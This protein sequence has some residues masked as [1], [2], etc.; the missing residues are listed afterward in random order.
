MLK[1]DLERMKIYLTVQI[2]EI[3]SVLKYEEKLPVDRQMDEKIKNKLNSDLLQLKK[4][5]AEIVQKI[6]R[7]HIDSLHLQARKTLEELNAP[8]NIVD[9]LISE[10]TKKPISLSELPVIRKKRKKK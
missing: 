9:R 8:N 6:K 3:T 10:G 1:N 5:R 4:E 7:F 2:Q